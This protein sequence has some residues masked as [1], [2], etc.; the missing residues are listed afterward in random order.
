MRHKEIRVQTLAL[1]AGGVG[2][3]SFGLF[4]LVARSGEL[5]PRPPLLA[6]VLL[7]VMGG[8]VLWLARPVRQYLQGRAT[9]SLDP[10]RA[11]RVVVLAQA[12]ALT[13]AAAA[14]WYA[15]QLGVVLTELSLVANRSRILPLGVLV[16]AGVLLA[17]AG[18]VAQRWCRIDP[19]DDQ[20]EPTRRDEPDRHER[21]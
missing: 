17:T 9:T 16:V 6:A 13:G 5:V 12:A 4:Q 3:A 11:A 7:T 8:L 10:L 19:A 2:I 15:G 21:H 20:D 14:G 1:V 18:L